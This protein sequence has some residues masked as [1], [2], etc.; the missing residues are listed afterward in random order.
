MD[1]EKKGSPKQFWHLLKQGQL[2]KSLIVFALILG[3]I[4]SGAGL[5]IPLFTRDFIDLLAHGGIRWQQIILLLSAFF[6]QTAAG[7]VSFYLMSYAGEA[8]VAQ[9]R[10]KLWNHV[11]HLSIP[12]FDRHESGE[13][14]SRITQDT[15]VI[16][17]LIS[18]HLVTF[19]SGIVSVIGSVILLIILDWRITLF[20][21]LAVPAAMLIVM[22]LGRKM[23]Q[24]SLR[25]QDEL[26]K[27]SGHL[28]RILQDIRLVKS[29]NGQDVEAE[30]GD[31]EIKNL[32]NFGLKEAKVYAVISPMIATVMMLVVVVIVGYG[33][34][35][36][37]SGHLTAGALVAIII[38]IF[39]IV[40]PFTAMA[41]FF[42]TFQKALG[43]TERINEMFQEKQELS[44]SQKEPDFNQTLQFEHVSFSY[45]KDKPVLKGIHFTIE[46]GKTYAFVGPSGGGKT[47]IFSL[48]ERFYLPNEGRILLGNVPI[49][50]IDLKKWRQAIGYV[51]QDIPILSGTI[52]ENICYGLEKVPRHEEIE[53]ASRLANA[54]EFIQQLPNGYET[55][56][57]ERGV[58]LSG[59]Q[60][61]RIAIARAILKNPKLLLLDEATSN[62]DSESEGLVQEALKNVM[63]GRTTLIIAHRLS[64]V[65]DADTIF[66]IEDG[67]ITG[68]GNHELLLATHPLYRK[69]VNHQFIQGKDR[70]ICTK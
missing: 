61:Q 8:L 38:Y 59:G 9:I 56:V 60:R 68:Q 2:K 57:G 47:T 46:P 65:T 5:I 70:H 43:A 10:K 36:V 52:Q 33:G 64:T 62:L 16:K 37:A 44:G 41:S 29:Y 30:K 69:L 53:Q 51:S 50:E 1:M 13:T 34:A 63:K 31:K 3:L 45:H 66:V 22:P 26:A 28:G 20:I 42:T 35:R 19:F 40:M 32:M 54:H 49:H 58:K 15:A 48:I 27:F 24:I 23:H 4:E 21:F 18:D 6:V 12:F 25:T 39:Q 14:M 17:S 55:E 67:R 11:L 7:G